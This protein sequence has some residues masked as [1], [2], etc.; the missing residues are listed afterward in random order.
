MLHGHCNR[1]GLQIPAFVLALRTH[2]D[3]FRADPRTYLLATWWRLCGLKLRARNLM[4]PLLGSSPLA[5]RRWLDLDI[6][7]KIEVEQ[8]A[9]V[10]IIA[11]IAPHS[12]PKE[13]EKTRTSILR[14]GMHA[15]FLGSEEWPETSVSPN[16]INWN[17]TPWL[18]P[19]DG[20][21]ILALGSGPAYRAAIAQHGNCN[22]IYADDDLRDLRDKR[23]SPCFKPDWNGELFSGS[24]F[25]TGACILEGQRDDFAAL[26]PTG[27]ARTLVNAA[28]ARAK[29]QP[30]RAGDPGAPAHIRQ[31]LHHRRDRP[32]VCVPLRTAPDADTL[33]SLSVIIPTRNR[34]ELLRKCL[35][36]LASTSYPDIEIIVVD[37]DSDDAATLAYLD[38]L[39]PAFCRVLRHHGPFNFSA[40]NNHAVRESRGE[41]LCLLNNDVEI[42]HSD[43]LSILAQQ[44]LRKDVGAAGAQ[45]LYPDGRIQHAGVVLGVG[46][47]AAHA[48]RLFYPAEEGYF[49]RHQLPQFVSAVTAA[50]L[51][52]RR[53]RFDAVGGLDEEHFT[54]SF[55]DVDLCM[56]LNEKGWQSLYEPRAQLIHHESISRG[57]DRDPVGA[58][59]L[60]SELAELKARWGTGTQV[61]PYHHP[62]LSP[63]SERFVVRL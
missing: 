21:D 22:L 50:C 10:Q 6:K 46:G 32:P 2:F 30:G 16:T 31:I 48:H 26:P 60:A 52:V 11:L 27:W 23:C 7:R 3:A 59:R 49:Q 28:L 53:D 35:E 12:D 62:E 9:P 17:A 13:N 8:E 55:N 15:I 19:M 4:S 1:T 40:I 42:V 37:N 61:D 39:D 56:K 18:M 38:Q 34:L 51:V 57:F 25:L 41:L 20:G 36:G 63:F 5:Y 47:G 14:E 45:L 44:A 43:W 24:D 54:V 29:M 58:A 33:P